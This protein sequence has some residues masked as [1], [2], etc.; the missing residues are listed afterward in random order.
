MRISRNFAQRYGLE[1]CIR[2]DSNSF[3]INYRQRDKKSFLWTFLRDP[4]ERALSAIGSKLSREMLKSNSR[5]YFFNTSVPLDADTNSD[6][7]VQSSYQFLV[8]KTLDMLENATDIREGV[9]SEGRGGFQL[10][11]GM[12]TFIP[13]NSVINPKRPTEIVHH[14]LLV[15]HVSRVS[16]SVAS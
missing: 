10:Q 2:H 14:S 13:V 11:Y 1:N 15:D 5:D 9:L 3:G 12:Q 16:F 8:N 6:S 4:T 7:M